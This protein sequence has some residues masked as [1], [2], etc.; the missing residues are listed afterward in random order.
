MRA[1]YFTD[2]QTLFD[3]IGNKTRN[4]LLRWHGRWRRAQ[5]AREVAAHFAMMTP[6]LI[7][8]MTPPI[9][10]WN[11]HLSV[12]QMSAI[13]GT[14]W[15]V[16]WWLTCAFALAWNDYLCR[17]IPPGRGRIPAIENFGD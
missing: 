5:R 15:A 16:T 8:E 12:W 4:L 1:C 9:L 17:A 6:S 7:A 13:M 3:D 2:D 10:F 11:D 14:S